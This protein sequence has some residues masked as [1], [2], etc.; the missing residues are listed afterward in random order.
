M[1]ERNSEA[2]CP[3]SYSGLLVPQGKNGAFY[4]PKISGLRGLLCCSHHPHS[5]FSQVKDS[6]HQSL[7]K[8][9]AGTKGLTNIPAMSDYRLAGEKHNKFT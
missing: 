4:L 2:G 3:V 8:T 6:T 9:G 1:R 7:T 5:P